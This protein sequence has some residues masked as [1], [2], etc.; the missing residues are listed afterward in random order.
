MRII[1]YVVLFAITSAIHAAPPSE[2]EEEIRNEMWLSS[3][4]AF[5]VIET[6][7]KWDDQSAVVIAQLNRFEYRKPVMRS[8]ILYNDY[9]HYRIKLFDKKAVAE[10]SEIS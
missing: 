5:K 3:D 7:K 1:L 6:P 9:K 4:N 2:R 8:Q 10:Y